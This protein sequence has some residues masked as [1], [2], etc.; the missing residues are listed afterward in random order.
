MDYCRH[1]DGP[2]TDEALYK[3]FAEHM[4]D[5]GNGT[6]MAMI[7]NKRLTAWDGLYTYA[8]NCGVMVDVP[9][10]GSTPITLIAVEAYQ[11]AFH[12]FQLAAETTSLKRTVIPC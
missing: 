6:K 7:P 10:D 5:F 4:F 3:S 1:Q 12:C 11:G 8:R 2:N 9:A